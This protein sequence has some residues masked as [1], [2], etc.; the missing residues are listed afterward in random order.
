MINT[1]QIRDFNKF[2]FSSKERKI[3]SHFTNEHNDK[4][5]ENLSQLQIP[6]ELK[7]KYNTK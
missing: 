6:Q 5:K 3:I 7:K 1:F 4:F 2:P